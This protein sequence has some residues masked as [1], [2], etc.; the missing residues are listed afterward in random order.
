MVEW[1]RQSNALH[2]SAGLTRRDVPR[3]VAGS[4][5]PIRPGVREVIEWCDRNAVPLVVMSAGIGTLRTVVF[6]W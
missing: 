1:H 4:A 6:F 5:L 2:V 3:A